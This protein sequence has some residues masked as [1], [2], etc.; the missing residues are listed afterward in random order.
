MVHCLIQ[1]F[2]RVTGLMWFKQNICCIKHGLSLL[3]LL[4]HPEVFQD[5]GADDIL[6]I[7]STWCSIQPAG[8]PDEEVELLEGLKERAQNSRER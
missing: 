1:S 5:S 6:Y 3:I 2:G 7:S 8:E 4:S